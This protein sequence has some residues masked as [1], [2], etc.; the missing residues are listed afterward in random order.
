MPPRPKVETLPA[1]I[2]AELDA[3]LIKAGFGDYVALSEWLSEHGFTIS[4]S[5]LAVYG[6]DFEARVSALQRVTQQARAIVA[7]TPDDDGAVN[8]ALIRLV[9][10]KVFGVLVDLETELSN[11]DLAK[12]TKAV[13]DLS[14][15]SVSQKKLAAEIR[16]DMAAKAVKAVDKALK[17]AARAGE[18]GLS[19]DLVTALRRDLAG[20]D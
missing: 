15:A 17:S 19:L 16:K 8:D 5:S 7:E 9:Q 14:R 18:K 4:K 3:R 1:D 11:G 20:V 6:K 13:A 10:E 2:R 12:V